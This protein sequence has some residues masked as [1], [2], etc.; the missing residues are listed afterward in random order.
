LLHGGSASVVHQ[1]RKLTL[2]E[3]AEDILKDIAR[4]VGIG[5][6]AD[7][8]I[9]VAIG[10]VEFFQANHVASVVSVC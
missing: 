5:W 1:F 7:R 4:T 9:A 8:T 2:D 3:A 6:T 10:P